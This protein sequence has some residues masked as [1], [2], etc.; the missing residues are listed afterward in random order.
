M[1][2]KKLA[3]IDGESIKAQASQDTTMIPT[4][5]I[6]AINR[7]HGVAT[8][9]AKNTLRYAMECG[10]LLNEVRSTIAHGSW[11]DWLAK[12]CPTI[13]DRT[14]RLYRRLHEHCDA[15]ESA[16]DPI[17]TIGDATRYIAEPSAI[18]HDHAE[19]E[20][21]TPEERRELADLKAQIEVACDRYSE[22]LLEQDSL[23][24]GVR[25]ILAGHSDLI[26]H[27]LVEHGFSTDLESVELYEVELEWAKGYRAKR[28]EQNG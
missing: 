15:I 13:R 16:T 18:Q 27:C 12:Y 10:S 25:E 24:A 6:T 14:D 9:A 2:S 7:A 8:A 26:A 23:L 11:G 22:A 17:G 21:L 19:V 20:P 5:K 28:A 4:A 1:S 3:L